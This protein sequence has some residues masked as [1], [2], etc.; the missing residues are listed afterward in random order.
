MTRQAS[1]LVREGH[2]AAEVLV[3]LDEDGGDWGPTIAPQDISKLDR[4]RAALRSG[5]LKLAE[6]DARLFRLVP[7]QEETNAVPGF[8]DNEQDGYKP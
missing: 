1:Q 5:D 7:Y 6:K 8:G 3:D 2:Y 4:V